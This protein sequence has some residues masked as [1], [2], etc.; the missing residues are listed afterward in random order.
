MKVGYLIT[1]RLKSTRLPMKLMQTACGRPILAHMLDRLKLCQRVDEI[2]VCTSTNPQDTPLVD[3]ALSEGVQYFCGDEDD[4]IKRLYDAAVEFGIDYILNIT[5]DC[6]FVDPVYADRI[7]NTFEA[8]NADLI[9]AFDLPHGAYSYG[10]KFESLKRVIEIKDDKNT[11]VWGR[12]FT[13]TDLFEIFDLPIDNPLHRQPGLRMT[14][15]YPEDLEFFKTIFEQLYEPGKV[16]SLDDILHFL[17]KHPEVVEIN[18]DCARAFKKRVEKQSEIKLRSRYEIK[19]IAIL[20]CGSIGQ[21]HIRNLRSLGFGGIFALRSRKGHFDELDPAFDVKEV[22]DWHEV[23]ALE[24]DVAI[25]SNPT[26]LHLETALRLVPH[27][28]GLFIEKP[29][30]S[31]LHGV[32]ELLEQIKAHKLISFVG[33]DLQYHPGVRAIQELLEGEKLGKPLIFQCQVGQWLPDWHPYE[34]YRKAYYA[35]K[36]LGGGVALT[37]IH[38]VHLAVELLGSV[39]AVSCLL[40]RS[41]LLPLKVDVIADMMLQHT[42]GAVSQIHLDYIQR[43]PHRCGI[44]SCERGW[45]SYDLFLQKVEVN[46]E[47]ENGPRIAWEQ[48]DYD[49]NEL[50]LEEMSTFLRYVSEGRVRHEF[51]AWQGTR[52]LAVVDAAFKSA[53]SGCLSHLPDWVLE[54]G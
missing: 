34:D 30:A 15:D 11:E 23:I 2:I 33:Y 52:S 48:V 17:G 29:L 32:K 40:P 16:F 25:I 21:R 19:R 9:R 10:I 36:D 8:T 45:I 43:L 54:L 31:S 39:D 22:Q 12:Y 24:P 47:G 13:D 6:P 1:A 44:I 46:F 14:L 53:E 51:D 4:V 28:R 38:D 7:V 37:I 42:S 5:A 3:L 41:D 20:G 18:R 49:T 26:S 50:Y 27:V 35:R